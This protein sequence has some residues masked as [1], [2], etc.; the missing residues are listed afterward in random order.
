ML[1]QMAIFHFLWLINIYIYILLSQSYIEG[2]LGCCFHVL[3]IANNAGINVG[4]HLSFLVSFYLLDIYNQEQGCWIIKYLYFSSIRKHTVFHNGCTNLHSLINSIQGTSFLCILSNICY[5]YTFR[6][7]PSD[8]CEVISHVAFIYISLM[9]S[10]IVY[11][12]MCLLA[13]V[14]SLE[15]CLFRSFA[16]FWLDYCFNIELHELFVHFLF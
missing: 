12:F 4:M 13:W 14:F 10:D 7:Y 16:Y 5:L 3:A 9:I 1:L 11:L 6:W 15:K 2:H 8:Q